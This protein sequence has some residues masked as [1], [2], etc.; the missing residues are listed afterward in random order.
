VHSKVSSCSLVQENEEAYEVCMSTKQIVDIVDALR[1]VGV[2]IGNWSPL[3]ST[4][5]HLWEHLCNLCPEAAA[6]QEAAELAWGSD[7]EMSGYLE[8]PCHQGT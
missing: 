8:I 4:L 7:D 2:A 1:W 5:N 6:S 3:P